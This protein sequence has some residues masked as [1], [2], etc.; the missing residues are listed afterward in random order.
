MPSQDAQNLAPR[1][2]LVMEL[3]QQLGFALVGIAPAQPS[4]HAETVRQWISEGRHGEM[5]YLAEHLDLRLDP[6]RLL[7]GARSVIAVADLYHHPSQAPAEAEARP[8][9]AS[10]DSPL[11]R[12][13][14]RGRVAR[15]AWGED[16][17][18]VIKKRL[19]QMA[20]ALRERFPDAAFRCTVDTAPALEREHAMRAGLGWVGKH[21]LLIHPRHGSWTLLGLILTTLAIQDSAQAGFPGR[22]V[23]PA[24]HCGTCTRCIDACPTQCIE[25]P[26]L[27][28]RRAID[29]TRCISYLTLEHRGPIDPSLHRAMGD[30]IAGCDVCQEVCPF[31]SEDRLLRVPEKGGDQETQGGLLA[32]HPS[33]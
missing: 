19:H 1:A 23:V 31:N 20:D 12:G 30:W 24:D 25:N 18:K 5:H 28:G 3:A 13:R 22:T 11:P 32:V 2:R 21:T 10:G 16:Y 8:S 7:P 17:H 33:Y 27:T 26:D 4:E 6:A 14:V 29:A 9:S 15:Y